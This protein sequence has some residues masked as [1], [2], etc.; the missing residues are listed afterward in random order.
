MGVRGSPASS[1]DSQAFVAEG[2]EKRT[3]AQKKSA[4]M[5]FRPDDLIPFRGLA[6]FEHLL[7]VSPADKLWCYSGNSPV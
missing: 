5:A 1:R 6:K 7:L 4:L 2:N 3:P